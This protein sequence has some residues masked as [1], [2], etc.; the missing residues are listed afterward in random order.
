MHTE[1]RDML[2]KWRWMERARLR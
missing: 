2:G 1:S